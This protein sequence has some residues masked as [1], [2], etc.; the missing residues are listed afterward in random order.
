MAT[1]PDFETLLDTDLRTLLSGGWFGTDAFEMIL[2]LFRPLLQTFTGPLRDQRHSFEVAFNSLFPVLSH[3]STALL[4]WFLTMKAYEPWT[5]NI[6]SA[7]FRRQFREFKK[8]PSPKNLSTETVCLVFNSCMCWWFPCCLSLL[9]I[10]QI[11]AVHLSWFCF[12]RVLATVGFSQYR[13]QIYR[14]TSRVARA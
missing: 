3:S 4:A 1:S 2:E 12:F 8:L 6:I 10:G 11:T 14:A 13:S 9:N 7:E 5:E